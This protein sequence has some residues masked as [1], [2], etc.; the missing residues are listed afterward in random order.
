VIDRN[1][2]TYVDSIFAAKESDYV[3]ATQRI[4]R[5]R[6][7]PSSVILPVLSPRQ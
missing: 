5:S 3:K 1:P 4:F 6:A 2:Q 7:A